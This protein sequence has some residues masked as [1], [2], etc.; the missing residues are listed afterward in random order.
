CESTD[1]VKNGRSCCGKQR[2]RCNSCKK[3]FQTDYSYNAWKA[4]T[5]E[6]IDKMTLNGSG[7]REIGRVLNIGKDTV[8]AHLKKRALKGK[9]LLNR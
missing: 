6:Q 4:G 7:V 2:Y 9:P 8:T 1:L 5:K 3:Y